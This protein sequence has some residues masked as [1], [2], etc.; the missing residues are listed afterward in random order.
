MHTWIGEGLIVALPRVG[1]LRRSVD[2]YEINVVDSHNQ[3]RDGCSIVWS[4]GLRSW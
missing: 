2:R 3:A 1:D 4:C